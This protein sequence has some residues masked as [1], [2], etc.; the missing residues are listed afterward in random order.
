MNDVIDDVQVMLDLETFSTNYNA[1]I[2]S[3]GA[4]KF[5]GTEIL[6][7]FYTNINAVS[8]KEFG[9]HISK[10]TLEWWAT[11]PEAFAQLKAA[12]KSLPQALAA[13]SEWYGIK[14]LPTWGNG[15]CFD[16]VIIES[17]FKAVGAKR[18][19]TFKHD[20]CYRTM[21]ELFPIK[22]ASREGTYHNALDDAVYQVK[23]LQRIFRT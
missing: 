2:V 14:H 7:K 19:W 5:N 4:V 17:A 15:A 13:F 22:Y 1:C 8:C 18:P 9:L 23:H 20:R 10:D 21:V 11:K 6:D 16:N 3:I 12:K